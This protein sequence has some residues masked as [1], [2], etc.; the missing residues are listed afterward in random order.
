MG[1]Q[2]GLACSQTSNP[3]LQPILFLLPYAILPTEPQTIPLG[4]FHHA[5][6]ATIR[7]EY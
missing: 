6:L 4:I 2:Y 1:A 7:P 3:D 5:G